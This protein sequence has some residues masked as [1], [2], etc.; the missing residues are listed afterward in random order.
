MC[1]VRG[2][3]ESTAATLH[4]AN[5][6]VLWCSSVFDRLFQGRMFFVLGKGLR[7]HI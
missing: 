3:T 2:F 6:G 5:C 1:F 4:S 7:S